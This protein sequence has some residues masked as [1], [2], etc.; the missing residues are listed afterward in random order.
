M[1][2]DPVTEQ[3]L[4]LTKKDVAGWLQI[5]ETGVERLQAK[6]LP[7]IKFGEGRSVLRFDRRDVVAFV[8][9]HRRVDLTVDRG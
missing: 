1:A 2:Y 3:P 4:L 6:G 9:R 7:Y 5:S 8:A